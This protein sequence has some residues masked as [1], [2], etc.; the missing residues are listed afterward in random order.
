MSV[1]D[2]VIRDLLPLYRSGLASPATEAL[3]GAWLAAHPEFGETDAPAQPASSDAGAL[4]ALS[5]ARRLARWR[6]RL[7]GVS[8]GLTVLLFTT[9]LTFDK[10]HLVAV[11]LV[12]L[13]LPGVFG[14]IALCAAA[15]WY[16]Y[17][18]LSA[19]VRT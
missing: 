10:G 1:S 11:H 17:W 16:G 5:E 4:R 15:G 6:R 12:A 14:P 8:I 3:V 13:E 19:R 2:D 7:Y 18:R 9:R